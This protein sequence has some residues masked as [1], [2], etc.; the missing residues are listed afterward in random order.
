MTS[1]LN[2][3]RT[4]KETQKFNKIL[5]ILIILISLFKISLI[6]KGFLAFPD[7]FIYRSSERALN[8]ILNGDIKTGLYEIF[9]TQGR[10]GE[11][12]VKMIPCAFQILTASLFNINYAENTYPMFIFNFIINCLI[13]LVHYKFS[14]LIFKDRFMGLISVL[15]FTSL[16]NSYIYLRHILPYDTSLLIFYYVLY[17][18]IKKTDSGDLKLMNSFLLGLL[19]FFG[20]VIYPGY[21]PLYLAGGAM[22]FLNK[23]SIQN[24]VNRIYNALVFILGGVYCLI[25]AELISNFSGRSYIEDSITLSGNITQGSFEE[26]FSFLIK[27][28]FDV[29]GVSGIFLIAGLVLLSMIC[30]FSLR[31][32]RITDSPVILLFSLLSGLFV[33]YACLGYFNHSVVFYGRLLHQYYPFI[34]LFSLYAL[35]VALIKVVEKAEV[36]LLGVTAIFIV[37]FGYNLFQYHRFVYPRDVAYDHNKKYDIR[38]RNLVFEYGTSVSALPYEDELRFSA[39]SK[40]EEEQ[41]NKFVMVNFCYFY[42]AEDPSLFKKYMPDQDLK[43]IFSGSYFL[44]NRAYQY[45]GFNIIE[46]DNISGMDLQI[47]VFAR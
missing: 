27:Y 12:L 29:E 15:L 44:N 39:M 20:L 3:I 18:V 13:L 5:V 33:L 8:D 21:I 47:K 6:G 23:L 46:R 2:Y 26:S 43:Q 40:K 32:T 16:T 36:V 22:L 19:S 24:Y 28:L 38:N 34:C 45:E 9:S 10:P 11:A 7:E 14:E 42:P 41:Y 37:G 25:S 30:F 31:K 4:D 17:R 1:V 35:N